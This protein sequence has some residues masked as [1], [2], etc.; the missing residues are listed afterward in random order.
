MAVTDRTMRIV[1]DLRLQLDR[2]VDTQTSDLVRA[3]AIAWDEVSPDLQAALAELLATP[4]DRI[5]RAQMLRS[6]RLMQSLAIIADR[7]ETLADEAG[8]RITGDL[9]DVIDTAGTAQAA[10]I[11]SQLPPGSGLVNLQGWDRVDP[12]QLDAIVTRS[13][14][15]IV[16]R[17]QPLSEDVMN[18]VRRELVRGVAA[19]SNP[20]ETA[21]RMVQRVEGH[22][23]GRWGLTRALVISRTETLDA[24]RAAARVAQMQD[25]HADVLAEWEWVCQLDS[26]SCPACW[27]MHG[28]RFPLEAPGPEDH[29]QGRCARLPRTKSWADLGF[30]IEEPP[31]LLPDAEQRFTELAADEQRTILGPRRF[32][33]WQAGDYPMGGWATRRENPDWRPSYQVSP[34]PSG[35]R[36]SR[37]AA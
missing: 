12:R 15:R 23:N 26:R 35:G 30:D 10:I 16:S 21:R 31:D 8:V 18:V 28:T 29:P 3:W 19:G 5:T 32:E 34:A 37:R 4:G 2:V 7:L 9:Q 27:S 24:H 6:R 33:A 1:Q 20:R 25:A 22:V 11:D 17:L 14:E 36:R 13:T